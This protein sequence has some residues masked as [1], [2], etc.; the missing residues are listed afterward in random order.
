MRANLL[1]TTRAQLAGRLAADRVRTRPGRL[2]PSCLVVEGPRPNVYGLA[3]WREGLLEVQDEASQLV[4]AAVGARPGEA[5]LDACAGAGGKALLLAADVG[6]AGRVH[7]ADP[8]AG[9]LVRLR[10]RAAAA[11]AAEIV[12]LHGAEAPPALRVDRALV[13]APCSELGV[14]RRGP[15]V[16]WRLDPAAFAALPALQLGILSRTARHVRSGGRLVY[17]T[18]TFRREEDEEV[19]LA[20]EAAHPEYARIALEVDA[21]ALT[22]DG[23]VRTWPHRHGTDGFFAAAWVRA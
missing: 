15:D 5:V 13:D 20:F 21:S 18:C 6:G 14:L 11:G 19:A 10:T 3:A 8:D 7:V 9:R 17:A 4:G 12:A 22:P 23:F 2:A 16:R 1:R